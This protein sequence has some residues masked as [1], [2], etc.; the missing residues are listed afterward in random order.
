LK[1][2]A[3][4]DNVEEIKKAYDE[5]SNLIQQIGAA[6]YGQKPGET[7]PQEPPKEEPPA[8]GEEKPEEKKE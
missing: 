3:G 1:E 8:G 6:M 5:L 7:P 2:A 4:K